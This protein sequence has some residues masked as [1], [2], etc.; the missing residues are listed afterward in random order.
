MKNICVLVDFTDTS[1][2]AIRYACDLANK[3][4]A[5]LQILHVMESSAKKP[6]AQVEHELEEFS[7][8]SETCKTE[9]QFII[10]VGSFMDMIP[11]LL[12]QHETDLVIIATHGVKGI[13]HTVQGSE[14]L[15]LVQS[16]G[17]PAIIMQNQTPPD[18]SDI[19]K[20]LFPIASHENFEIKINQT[21]TIA[22][23][24][25]AEVQIFALYPE[26]GPP[27]DN[28][29]QNLEKADRIFKE[30]GIDT[31]IVKETSKV[32]GIGYAKQALDYT[33]KTDIQLMSIM[34]HAPDD[35]NYFGNVE[36]SDFILN[37][38]GIPV[39]CCS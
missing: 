27:A 8:L 15:K 22:S 39:L 14:V 30:K 5:R 26:D 36:R 21:A 25:G 20:I 31:Q 10:E 16:F 17:I 6:A 37:S 38:K 1:K 28:L 18:L 7:S 34:S 9:Y 35:L 29:S 19:K 23:L 4:Q 11:R 12:K 24:F 13:F 33:S 32:Y 2:V 3:A